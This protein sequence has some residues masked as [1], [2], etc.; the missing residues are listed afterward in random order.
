MAG[1]W[2][3]ELLGVLASVGLWLAAA[4]A[5]AQV[6][7]G[8]LRIGMDADNTTMDPHLSTAAVDRQVYNNIYGK[9]F[10]I[11][12]KFG[13]VPQL[14]QS[15]EVKS[16]GL[17]YVFKLR[18]GVKFHDGTDFNADI[19]KW[20]FDR[21]RDPALASPRRSEIAP[22]KDVK[23]VDPYTVELTLSAPYAPLLSVLTDRAGMMVS[24]AAVEKYKD[25][26]A[27]NPVGT[28][29]FRFA[30]WVKDDH[31]TIKRFEGYWEKG[32][33][34]LD[35]VIYRPIP[36]PS[37]R[38]TAMRTGQ[39]DVMHQIAPKDVAAAKSEKGI[40]VSEIPSL[41]WQGMHL[42]NQVAPFTSK[43]IRQAIWYAVDRTVIQRVAYQG[44]G[45]PAWGPF[46]SSMWAQ[47][48]DFSD[49]RRDPAKAKTKLA[50]GGMPNGFS[51]TVKGLPAQVQELQIIQ[52]QLKDVGVDMKIEQL[53]FGKLLADLNSHNF[54]ALR[55]GWSG[56]PD[57]DGNVHAF[58]HS[59][60]GLNRVRYSN[61][62]MDELLDAARTE[63]DQAKRKALYAQISRIAAEDAPYIWI[64]HDAEVKVWGDQVKGFEHISDGMIRVKGVWLDKK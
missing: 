5:D 7:G 48:T 33:P 32:L 36:D 50:E 43:P 20:N 49:W 31:L 46:P 55:I 26:Y 57:P 53:E 51:F 63:G 37:V 1:R 27:R 14:V 44:L 21:M 54:V 28:G 6:R 24:K 23:V 59:K 9:L 13:I 61:P 25:D 42:N 52:A 16:G 30:E 41:W 22:V 15:W 4:P 19:V 58:L 34:H 40:K 29:P 12:M 8:T 45:T 62:K 38:F 11:D 3:M 10:D 39:I 47:D 2:R 64:H 56:R 60:G 18:R 17:V 35:E